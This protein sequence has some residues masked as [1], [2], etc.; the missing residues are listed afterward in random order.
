MDNNLINVENLKPFPKFFYT[1]GMLPTSFR[2][3]MTYEE[4]VLEIMR[5]I[6]DEIIPNVNQNILAT[7]E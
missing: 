2:V 5:F 6:K 3:T 7:K 4:Q 1:L